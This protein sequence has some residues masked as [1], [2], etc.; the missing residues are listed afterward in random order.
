[1]NAVVQFGF[2]IL[3]LVLF[4]AL[5][6]RPARRQRENMAHLQDGLQV[7]DEVVTA[8]GIFGSV[9]QL[10]DTR[11]GLEIAP[12]VVIEIARQAVVRKVDDAELGREVEDAPVDD[13]VSED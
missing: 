6:M 7:G 9:A 4:W 12:G 13:E 5:A 1:M 11:I 10:A 8:S 3:L 2:L